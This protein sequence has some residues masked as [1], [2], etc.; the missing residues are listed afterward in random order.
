MW[1]TVPFGKL[2]KTLPESSNSLDYAPI[3]QIAAT[4]FEMYPNIQYFISSCTRTNLLSAFESMS[5]MP[6]KDELIGLA[7]V[8]GSKS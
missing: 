5:Y 3:V 8:A 4:F 2:Q 1:E 6:H 7:P